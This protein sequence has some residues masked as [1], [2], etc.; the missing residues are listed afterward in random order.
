MPIDKFSWVYFFKGEESP[1]P[2]FEGR[3][4]CLDAVRLFCTHHKVDVPDGRWEFFSEIPV[5]QGM[6]SSTADIVATIRCLYSIFAIPYDESTVR[7]ILSEIERADSV[8]LNEFALYLSRKHEVVQSF[9]VDLDFYA[10]Y[11]IEP[12]FVKTE[13]VTDQLLA[14]YE[15]HLEEYDDVRADI[16]AGFQKRDR[17]LI[18]AASSRSANLAQLVLPKK[19]FDVVSEHRKYFGADGLLVAHTGTILGYLY[20]QRPSRARMNELSGFFRDLGLQ[21]MFSRIGF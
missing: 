9:G 14:H 21:S 10:C 11:T 19:H 4:K 3:S 5:G 12:G 15:S 20:A 1:V 13:G 18:A 17:A 8:F 16:I 2:A 7:S 6:A